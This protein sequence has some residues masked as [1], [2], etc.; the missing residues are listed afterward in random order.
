MTKI[1]NLFKLLSERGIT[2]AKLSLDTKISTG[3]ISDWKSGRASPSIEKVIQ[4]ANYFNVST[5]YLLGREDVIY[6]D[7]EF[8]VT[9][10]ERELIEKYRA[11]DNY[12]RETVKAV[13]ESE[14]RHSAAG[15]SESKQKVVL[16]IAAYGGDNIT[17]M[18]DKEELEEAIRKLKEQDD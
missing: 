18:A 8:R 16:D 15:A 11:I 5:D 7:F 1:P 2:A 3:N 4:L 14:Y 9:D 10:D 6:S 12:G 13:L 17:V